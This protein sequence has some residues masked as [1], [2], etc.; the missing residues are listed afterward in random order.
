MKEEM[1]M[2]NSPDNPDTPA[3]EEESTDA[4]KAVQATLNRIANNAAKR[5][6]LRQQRYDAE[7]GIFTR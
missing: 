3:L 1:T 2:L 5:G 6:I 4:Q 7:H